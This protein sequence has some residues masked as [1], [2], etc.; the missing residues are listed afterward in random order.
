MK[1]KRIGG[2]KIKNTIKSKEHLDLMWFGVNLTCICNQQFI[3]LL[4][5]DDYKLSDL[6]IETL[7]NMALESHQIN[8]L[9]F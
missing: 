3:S 1:H 7:P 2:K 8:L 5:D 4:F 9:C 6:T